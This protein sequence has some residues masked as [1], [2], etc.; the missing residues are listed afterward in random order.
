ME[1]QPPPRES[2]DMFLYCNSI[3][4]SVSGSTRCVYCAGTGT[5]ELVLLTVETGTVQ[6]TITLLTLEH[7]GMVTVHIHGQLSVRNE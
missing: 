1:L 5:V 4:V 7:G 2:F 3:Q 6:A